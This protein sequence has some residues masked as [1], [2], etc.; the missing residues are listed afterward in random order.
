MSTVGIPI[1]WYKARIPV[2]PRKSIRGRSK[3]SFRAGAGESQNC[4]K[5]APVQ[6]WVAL[7]QEIFW[8]LSGPGPKRL[9][10]PSLIDFRGKTGIR[11]LYQAI[12]IPSQQYIDMEAQKVGK[13]PAQNPEIWKKVN[14]RVSKPRGSHFCGRG[15]DSV[16]D[17]CGTVLLNKIDRP[18]KRK[19]SNR[20]TPQKNPGKIGKVPKRIIKGQKRDKRKGQ[21]QIRKPPV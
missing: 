13:N 15:P 17:L 7:E 20:K 14:W 19:R 18:R 16:A 10:A 11:A 5:V 2:L 3:W 1:A 12:G 8:G 4:L 6:V 9:L 21:V